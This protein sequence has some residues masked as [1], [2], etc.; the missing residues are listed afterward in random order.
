VSDL[1]G[2]EWFNDQFSI[3]SHGLVKGYCASC[4]LVADEAKKA[5]QRSSRD[6]QRERDLEATVSRQSAAI[7]DLAAQNE[8][9]VRRIRQM[10]SSPRKRR[11]WR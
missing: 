4:S 1:S 3:C 8:F 10:Q 7:D 9:L 5:E 11:L 6:R 2:T